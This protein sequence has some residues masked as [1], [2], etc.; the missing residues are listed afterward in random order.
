M[1]VGT[2]A[3]GRFALPESEWHGRSQAAELGALVAGCYPTA[4]DAT[5]AIERARP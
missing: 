2:S 4:E 3:I 5:R 1:D